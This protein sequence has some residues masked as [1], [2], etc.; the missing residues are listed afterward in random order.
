MSEKETGFHQL[1]SKQQEERSGTATALHSK[2]TSFEF[3]AGHW[4]CSK[5]I[6]TSFAPSCQ[7]AG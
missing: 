1:P 6:T 3:Q 4:F 2:G 7:V 5:F